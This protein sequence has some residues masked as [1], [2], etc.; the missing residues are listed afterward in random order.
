MDTVSRIV[1]VD[2]DPCVRNLTELMLTHYGYPVT[3]TED[4]VEALAL[5]A[6]GVPELFIV[7]VFLPQP[8]SLDVVREL[9]AMDQPFE[10]LLM[11]TGGELDEFDKTTEDLDVFGYLYKPFSLAVLLDLVSRALSAVAQK[12]KSRAPALT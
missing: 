10:V 8:G 7:S 2:D 6:T 11:T 12:K 9:V 4:P 5:A 1:V 3:S